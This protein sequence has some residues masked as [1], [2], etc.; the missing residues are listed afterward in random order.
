MRKM[1]NKLYQQMQ[2]QNSMMQQFQKFQQNE[3]FLL[4]FPLVNIPQEYQNDPRGAVQYLMNNGQM[5]QDQFNKLSQMA[6]RM[7]IKL[8]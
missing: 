3:F 8:N 1:A 2:P 4:Y 6:Q 5:S 7:G